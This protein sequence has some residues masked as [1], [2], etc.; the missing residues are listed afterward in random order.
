MTQ[1][2]EIPMLLT[3]RLILAIP[4]PQA[5]AQVVAYNLQNQQHLTPWE[6][7]WTVAH[8]DAAAIADGLA[9]NRV[10]AAEGKAYRFIIFD[11]A[12]GIE[13]PVIGRINF[14]EI[15]RGPFQAC[16]LGYSLAQQH[17]SLGYMTEAAQAGIRYI[18]ETVKLHRIMANYMPHNERSAA[19]LRRL[20]FI[21]EGTARNYLYIGGAWRDHVLTSLTNPR[22]I[23]P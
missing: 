3:Q 4:Q 22:K 12:A 21:I 1:P 14:T 7:P 6:P 5:A 10:L 15:V 2:A 9:R 8:F 20:G 11:R 17:Q 13:G 19:L 18:F 16:Y 23:N